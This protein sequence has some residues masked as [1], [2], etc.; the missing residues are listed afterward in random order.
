MRRKSD[1]M[2]NLSW[3]SC[4]ITQGLLSAISNTET[5]ITSPDPAQLHLPHSRAQES[6]ERPGPTLVVEQSLFCPFFFFLLN[7]IAY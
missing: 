3:E 7:S 4:F 6:T 5:T 1:S 2:I